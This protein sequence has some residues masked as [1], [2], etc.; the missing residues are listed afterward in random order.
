[1]RL[2]QYHA[3]TGGVPAWE[4]HKEELQIQLSCQSHHRDGTG[5]DASVILAAMSDALSSNPQLVEVPEAQCSVGAQALLRLN[6][7]PRQIYLTKQWWWTFLEN[8]THDL[9]AIW[10][11]LRLH[12]QSIKV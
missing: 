3:L 10:L 9:D 1:V 6:Q 12:P 11:L 5:D 7:G 2:S 8:Y 4:R